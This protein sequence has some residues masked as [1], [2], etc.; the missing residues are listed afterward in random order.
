MFK[1]N[2]LKFKRTN[3]AHDYIN[4]P[5]GNGAIPIITKPTSVTLDSTSII[6]HI[7]TNDSNRQINSFIFEVDNKDHHPI[8]CKIDKRKSNILKNFT[9]CFIEIYQHSLQKTSV[10]TWEKISTPST[11]INLNKLVKT[12]VRAL[13]N[14]QTLYP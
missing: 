11:F 7:I 13:K 14:S 9:M 8:S 1:I 5:V 6:D 2:I 3:A 10:K 12:L 4:L